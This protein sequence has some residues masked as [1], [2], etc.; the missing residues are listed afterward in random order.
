ML[1][2]HRHHLTASVS[3]GA[4]VTLESRDSLLLRSTL[5]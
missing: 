3:K 4:P 2:Y 5:F 1:R